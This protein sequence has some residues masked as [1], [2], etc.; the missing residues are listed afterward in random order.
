MAVCSVRQYHIIQR[1]NTDF[2]FSHA[3]VG[4]DKSRWWP[5]SGPIGWGCEKKEFSQQ[6]R[7]RDGSGVDYPGRW[8]TSL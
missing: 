2:P 4:S 5:T 1:S 8:Q 6:L 3:L 7:R